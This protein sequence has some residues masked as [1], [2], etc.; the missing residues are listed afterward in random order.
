MWI[1]LG[2]KYGKTH[3][4]THTHA[5]EIMG[6]NNGIGIRHLL[7]KMETIFVSSWGPLESMYSRKP[8]WDC[9]SNYQGLSVND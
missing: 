2:E 9:N 1:H 8:W 4:H 6:E 3:V 7:K 5:Y